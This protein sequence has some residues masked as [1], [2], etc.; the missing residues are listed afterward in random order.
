MS[1]LIHFVVDNRGYVLVGDSRGVLTSARDR[2]DVWT[3]AE[4]NN[5]SLEYQGTLANR[6]L[7]YIKDDQQRMMFVLRWGQ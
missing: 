7:W 6:D 5:I 3:W 4:N 1:E 2:H